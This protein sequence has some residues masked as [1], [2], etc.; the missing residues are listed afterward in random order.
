MNP[1][2]TFATAAVALGV[3]L[4]GMQPPHVMLTG[5]IDPRDWAL[6]VLLGA[7]ALMGLLRWAGFLRVPVAGAAMLA[8]VVPPLVLCIAGSSGSR[9]GWASARSAELPIADARQRVGVLSGPVLHA[10]GRDGIV[11]APLWQALERLVVP[12]PLD[13][14]DPAGLAPLKRLLLVQ[15]RAL[16]PAE[17]VALDKWVRMGGHVVIL[18]DPDL[19]WADERPLGHPLRAPPASLLEPL[20][21]HWGVALA[22]IA[23]QP[24]GDPV[25]RHPLPD[26]RMVQIS[27]ASQIFPK[28]RGCTTDAADGLV[29]RCRIGRGTAVIVA[30]ADFANDGLWTATPD[31]PLS[32]AGWTS[33]AVPFLADLLVSGAGEGAGRRVWLTRADGLSGALRPALLLIVLLA[34]FTGWVAREARTKREMGRLVP[35]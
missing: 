33:D 12:V 22:P 20:L 28:A 19:R 32:T 18:A 21:R 15:P 26:G 3:L 29:A 23:S 27:G 10:P 30:D 25:Q 2:A 1:A 11:M 14:I 34:L 7:A 9:D 31:A 24:D 17:L 8:L 16:A 4:A 13:A 5:Q 35:D 6:P